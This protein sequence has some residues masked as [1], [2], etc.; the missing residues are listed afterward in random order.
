MDYLLKASG[1]VVMLFLFYVVFLKNETFFKSIRTYF[2][3]GLLI[4]LTIPLIE[5]PI[6]AEAITS[7]LNLLDYEEITPNSAITNTINWIQILTFMYLI[8]V[9]FFSLKFLIQLASL[10]SLIT[11]HELT[12]Q[13]KYY[14]IETSKDVSP[15]SFFNI[16]IYNKAQFSIDEL[17]QIKNHEKAHVQQWHSIDTL[18][19]HL[20]VITLWFNPFVWLYKKAVQQNLEFLADAKAL[21]QANNHKLYQ[22]TLLKTCGA[23]YCTE[24]TNNFYNSLIKKRIIMLHKNRSTKT[25]Q[26][27]YALLLP[28][29]IAFL[30]TFNTKVI[31]QEKKI[32]KIE[33]VNESKTEITINKNSKAETLNEIKNT[34]RKLNDITLNFKGIKRNNNNEITAIK[35]DAKG[36]GLK[37]KFE[38]SGSEAIKPIK[39]SYD[40]ENNSLSIS[41]LS[42]VH[43][44][45]Y[46]YTTQTNGT[47][48]TINLKGK[49]DKNGN[50]VFVTSDGKKIHKSGTLKNIELKVISEKGDKEHVWVHEN[51]KDNNIKVEVIELKEGEHEITVI[52]EGNED[53]IEENIEIEIHEE[54]DG[55]NVFV[56]KT[57]GDNIEKHK[58]TKKGNILLRSSENEKP[59]FIIDGKETSSEEMEKIKPDSIEKVEVLK[60][61]SATDKYGDKG[62]DGVILITTKK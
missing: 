40:S 30:I 23:N 51:D 41:N 21:E 17:E 27:K 52:Q 48:K 39:I 57:N 34:F 43:K 25:S 19:A 15:F 6:Y 47:I 56:I 35:I 60:G 32:I 62:N 9:V 44:N 38:N 50:Y 37:A 16:I 2:I 36:K 28:L 14:C 42:K 3:L 29:L 54:K 26:W 53:E 45:H 22:L 8:G 18:L 10:I 4:V 61:K 12:K 7:Q 59:L 55:E 5:I 58:I 31:A 13:G 11:K 24:I 46:E 33:E 1:I 49:G 20:L